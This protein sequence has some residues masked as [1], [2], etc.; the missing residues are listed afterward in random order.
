MELLLIDVGNSAVK[1]T[2]VD[3]AAVAT[4]PLQVQVDLHRGRVDGL[5]AR[6][7]PAW[8][9]TP[10][11][12]AVACTVAAADVVAEIEAAALGAG[13]PLTWLRAEPGFR[14]SFSLDNAYRDPRQLGADRWHALIGACVLRAQAPAAL[15]VATAG[16]ATTVDCLEPVSGGWRFIGGVIAPG[17]RL[18]LESLAQGTAG[19]PQAHAA[20]AAF[21][22]H[23]DA[24]IV[25]G[26]LDAQA[27]VIQRV[28]AR[29]AQRV[30]TRPQVLLGGGHAQ[31]LASLV[32]DGGLE[33]TI[34][35]NLVLRGL[36][37]RARGGARDRSE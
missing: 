18:M 4:A 17:V 28:A 21:P 31:A 8:Q 11:G 10:A 5:R 35:D 14:G 1:W 25:S 30:G 24:A 36:L 3:S 19:L 22:D 23:T 13:L 20:A 29:F 26:V 15:V 37:A 34:E 32:R 6:L 27:G 12:A 7:L 9:R 33:L 2:R 16:T